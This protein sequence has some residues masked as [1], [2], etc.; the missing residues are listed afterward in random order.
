M[1]PMHKQIENV[2]EEA[3]IEWVIRTLK[4]NAHVVEVRIESCTWE[5]QSGPGGE[6]QYSLSVQSGKKKA[7]RLGSVNRFVSKA[8]S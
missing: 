5:M 3:G 4:S 6:T 8:E 7:G 2:S 1:L